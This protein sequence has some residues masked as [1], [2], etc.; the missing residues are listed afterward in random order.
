MRAKFGHGPTVVPKKGGGVH[1]HK[2]LNFYKYVRYNTAN[3]VSKCGGD[4]VTQLIV[5]VYQMIKLYSSD[6]TKSLSLPA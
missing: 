3:N 1:T 5:N 2:L 4:P 6:T